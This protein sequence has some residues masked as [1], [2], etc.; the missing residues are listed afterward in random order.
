MNA[1][2]ASEADGRIAT[3]E[4]LTELGILSLVFLVLGVVLGRQVFG[5]AGCQGVLVLE[6]SLAEGIVV[7]SEGAGGRDAGG[8]LMCERLGLGTDGSSGRIGDVAILEM[9]RGQ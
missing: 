9:R 1:W 5:K 3:F 8:P 6:A 7:A 2:G 4:V